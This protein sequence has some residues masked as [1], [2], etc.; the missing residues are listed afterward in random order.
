[1]SDQIK[2]LVYSPVRGT[3]IGI[4]GGKGVIMGGK[5][6]RDIIIGILRGKGGKGYHHRHTG[7]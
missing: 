5:G 4:L 2:N 3:I 7:R 1:M 6:V